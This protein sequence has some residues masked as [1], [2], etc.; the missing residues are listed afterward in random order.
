[1]VFAV[2]TLRKPK[3]PAQVAIT[4]IGDEVIPSEVTLALGIEASRA[5]KKGDV[6]EGPP[7][8]P[9]P[10]GLWSLEVDDV[11]VAAAAQRLLSTIGEA[12]A[13]LRSVAKQMSAQVT[14]SIWWDSPEGQGGFSVPPETLGSL[15]A[16]VDRVDVYL[17]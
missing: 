16:L 7:A 2:N 11:E 10:W 9:R 3:A 6:V 1:M 4:L 15:C 12:S 8:H 14:L 17:P 5:F 13:R